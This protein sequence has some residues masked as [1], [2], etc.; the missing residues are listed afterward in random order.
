MSKDKI[1]SSNISMT[2]DTMQVSKLVE[3]YDNR[4]LIFDSKKKYDTASKVEVIESLLLKI[5]T[6]TYVFSYDDGYEIV[7]GGRRIEAIIGFIKG[8]FS[9]DNSILDDFEGMNYKE[10]HSREKRII[11][12]SVLTTMTFEANMSDKVKKTIFAR[13]IK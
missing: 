6:G 12:N 1:N 13:L 11:K 2:K 5:D 3:L 4:E 10:L 9:L 7:S 8:H